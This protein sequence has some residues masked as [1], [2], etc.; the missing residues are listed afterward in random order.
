M[1][2]VKMMRKWLIQYKEEQKNISI[3]TDANNT[4]KFINGYVVGVDNHDFLIRSF[5]PNGTYDGYIMRPIDDVFQIQVD[6]KYNKAMIQL[7]ENAIPHKSIPIQE[8]ESVIMSFLRWIK[9]TGLVMSV[10]LHQAEKLD[11]CGYIEQIG[12][13]TCTIRLL[14]FYGQEDGRTIVDINCITEIYC[15]T[16]DEQRLARLNRTNIFN[17]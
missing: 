3:Y 14:D 8:N 15:D 7:I 12:E 11:V 16:D 10:R 17:L 2:G 9:T 4:D 6:A 13:N 5:A 1:K